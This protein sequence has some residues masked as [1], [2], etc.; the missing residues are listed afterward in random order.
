M[1]HC[2]YF[3]VTRGNSSRHPRAI[4]IR[5]QRFPGRLLGYN[6][7][8]T[9]LD[10]RSI[11]P[12][13][14]DSRATTPRVSGIPYSYDRHPPVR[15]VSS[16]G[17]GCRGDTVP[18]RV[19]EPYPQTHVR[20]PGWILGYGTVPHRVRESSISANAWA[21]ASGTSTGTR[22]IDGNAFTSTS[23]VLYE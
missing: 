4:I 2:P 20:E 11:T 14:R 22:Y 13:R 7:S 17:R 21:R 9:Q 18:H 19:R 1:F 16:R 15:R 12:A 6:R 23:T 5:N 3:H 8:G 10:A